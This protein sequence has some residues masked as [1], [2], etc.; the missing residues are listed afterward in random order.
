MKKI[1]NTALAIIKPK[2]EVNE[3]ISQ[4][5]F[6][7]IKENGKTPYQV[8]ID[9][10]ISEQTIYN[11]Q[12]FG[13]KGVNLYTLYKILLAIN[14]KPSETTAALSSMFSLP[15][16]VSEG[17]MYKDL[18]DKQLKIEMY[19]IA[20]RLEEFKFNGHSNNRS[21]FLNTLKGKKEGELFSC[22]INL[23]W[24]VVYLFNMKNAKLE[25]I[26]NEII[27]YIKLKYPETCHKDTKNKVNWALKSIDNYIMHWYAKGAD[28]GVIN[29]DL[30]EWDYFTN[31]A[32]GV[33]HL[34]HAIDAWSNLTDVRPFE[35]ENPKLATIAKKAMFK[36]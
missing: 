9:A 6:K 13:S 29:L 7:L 16:V 32:E 33:A 1:E 25:G 2:E 36:I 31:S 24:T 14:P 15:T 18:T 10:G 5:I 22:A 35:E 23:D 26:L 12:K 3:R 34:N 20:K 17:R 27:P 4:L 11:Y 21:K 8:A 30:N 19:K 28:V